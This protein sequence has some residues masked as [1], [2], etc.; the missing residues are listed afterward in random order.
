MFLKG[1]SARFR[2]DAGAEIRPRSYPAQLS[3]YVMAA[4]DADLRIVRMA[5]HAVDDALARRVPRAEKY[6]GWPMLVVMTL[7]PRDGRVSSRLTNAES[8]KR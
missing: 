4:L 1:V 5:E 8:V 6:V 2:D 3:D 7:S